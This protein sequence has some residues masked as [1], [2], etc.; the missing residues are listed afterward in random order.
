MQSTPS[1]PT[2]QQQTR[3]NRRK[4]HPPP[5]ASS[6]VRSF[7]TALW[8]QKLKKKTLKHTLVKE[9]NSEIQEEVLQSLRKIKEELEADSWLYEV[10]GEFEGIDF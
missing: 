9:L 4:R 2:P 3:G 8:D 10:P 7:G 6:S 1:G 5:S